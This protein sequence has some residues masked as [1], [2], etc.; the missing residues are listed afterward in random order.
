MHVTRIVVDGV[1]VEML[2][3]SRNDDIEARSAVDVV[4][5]VET[6]KVN[7]VVVNEQTELL[8]HGTQQRF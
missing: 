3:A 1:L 8:N 6:V 7:E 5:R 2:Q 4:S